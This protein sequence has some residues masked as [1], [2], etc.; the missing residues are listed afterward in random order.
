MGTGEPVEKTI[1]NNESIKNGIKYQE[2]IL[3]GNGSNGHYMD[4][5]LTYVDVVA[6]SLVEAYI[7]EPDLKG[8]F[9]KEAT[10]NL[11]KVYETVSKNPD[12]IEYLK[13]EKRYPQ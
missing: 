4:D 13:S 12:I 2:D 9:S 8:F 6:Y 1:L 5:K 11:M 7:N 3:A 10:P